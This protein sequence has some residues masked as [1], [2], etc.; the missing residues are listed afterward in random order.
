MLL[1]TQTMNAIE[2]IEN[3]DWR[4]SDLDVDQ[5]VLVFRVSLACGCQVEGSGWLMSF[6]EVAAFLAQP[7]DGEDELPLAEA[8][9]ILARGRR[10]WC[11]PEDNLHLIE[12]LPAP[13]VEAGN[14]ETVFLDNA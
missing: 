9:Q 1:D 14:G 11:G 8:Q 7:D 6:Q 2:A 12:P 4:P 5:N 3:Q 10:V 13:T